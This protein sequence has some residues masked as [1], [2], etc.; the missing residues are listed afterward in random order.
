MTIALSHGG[1]THNVSNGKSDELLVGTAKGVTTLRR[2]GDGWKVAGTVLPEQ[3][4]SAILLEHGE[5]RIYAGAYRD[6]SLRVSHDGGT[7]WALCDNGLTEKD[8]FSIEAVEHDG[9]TRL[10][11]GTEPA[12]LFVSDDLGASWTERPTLREVPT[13]DSWSFPGPPHVAHAKH[14]TADPSTP[15]SCTSASRSAACCA[16]TTAATPGATYP[17]CTRTCIAS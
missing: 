11:V 1:P 6:G 17:A 5:R 8:V 16:P 13:V 12:K 4:I 15:T 14:I 7:T 10:Y 3:H 9:A 2:E